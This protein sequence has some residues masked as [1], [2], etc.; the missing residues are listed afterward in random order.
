MR[1]KKTGEAAG[2]AAGETTGAAL[3]SEAATEISNSDPQPTPLREAVRAALLDATRWLAAPGTEDGERARRRGLAVFGRAHRTAMVNRY[4][5]DLMKNDEDVIRAAASAMW[6]RIDGPTRAVQWAA[7]RASLLS[8]SAGAKMRRSA[9]QE[10]REIGIKNAEPEASVPGALEALEAELAEAAKQAREVVRAFRKVERVDLTPGAPLPIDDAF[11]SLIE[12]KGELGAK[13]AREGRVS[14][15]A[16]VDRA[17][18]D[19]ARPAELRGDPRAIVHLWALS[20]DD[21]IT[22]AIA[23]PYMATMAEVLWHDVVRPAFADKARTPPALVYQV[24]EAAAAL[25][26]RRVR[27]ECGD[28]QMALPLREGSTVRLSLDG[29]ALADAK[30]LAK[31]RQ[32][33]ALFG[34]VGGHRVIRDQIFT[35][36]RQAL[37]RNP[38]PRIIVIE[39]G[40]T[41]YAERLGMHGKKAAEQVRDV[42]EAENACEIPLPDGSYGRLLSREIRPARGHRPAHLKLILGTALLPHYVKEL[43]REMGSK[44]K[45]VDGRAALRLVPV[46]P[47]PPFVGGRSNE[48]GPQATASMDIV[49]YFRERARELAEHGGL[50]LE[51]I[52]K[53]ILVGAGVPASMAPVVLDR[54]CQDGDDAPAFLKRVGPDR[55]T[56][57]DAHAAARAF[58]EDAGRTSI[59]CSEAGRRSVA[60]RANRIR[61]GG[62]SARHGRGK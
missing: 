50:P 57:G 26:S 17:I 21:S 39:G 11:F 16:R 58:I 9:A 7:T 20:E 40:W 46:L 55:Y 28:G 31:V 35:G 18:E 47:L 12:G 5:V 2:E 36:H 48:H 29:P 32:G 44:A 38:D 14:S 10:A 41:A 8:G 62:A 25:F 15:A 53:A 51:A 24:H 61:R 37:E 23:P 45:T 60:A 19:E 22:K 30:A 6:S 27:I 52:F 54:W 4:V 49:A 56:L 59:D 42:V 34:S 43:Q 1:A 13:Y 3:G 33:V